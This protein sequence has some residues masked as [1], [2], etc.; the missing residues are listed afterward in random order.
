MEKE[1]KERGCTQMDLQRIFREQNSLY[2]DS[3]QAIK[4]NQFDDLLES[5]KKDPL[6]KQR[7]LNTH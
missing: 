7:I 1:W 4:E 2:M 6:L 3:E 5:I